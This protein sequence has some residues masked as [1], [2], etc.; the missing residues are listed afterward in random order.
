[1]FGV[2][3]HSAFKIISQRVHDGPVLR[4]G[5]WVK[6][7]LLLF[8]LGDFRYVLFA[9]VHRHGGFLTRLKDN[10]K[11]NLRRLHRRHRGRAMAIEGLELRA[12]RSRLRRAV[13]DAEAE[14]CFQR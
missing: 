6:G 8:D 5:Q 3:D 12:V 11:A 10:A 2:W 7:R 14:I 4:T 1:M 9:A 13:F